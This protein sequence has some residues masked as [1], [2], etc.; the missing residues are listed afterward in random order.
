MTNTKNSQ[1]VCPCD[2]GD[3]NFATEGDAY[4]PWCEH[5]YGPWVRDG[6]FA[7]CVTPIDY[8]DG[9][10]SAYEPLEDAAM[11]AGLFGWE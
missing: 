8:A 2:S 4:C 7:S 9:S 3:V 6:L 10:L 5:S 11:E 1:P